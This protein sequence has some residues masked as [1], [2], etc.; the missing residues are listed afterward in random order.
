MSDGFTIITDLGGVILAVDK[1]RMC[2]ELARYSTLS[3]REIQSN[4]STTKLT[5]FDL[6]FG[7]GL[8]TPAGFY[9]ASVAKLKLSGLS[10]GKFARIYTDVFKRK[11]DTIRL[12]RKLGKKYTVALLSNTDA[13]HYKAWSGML[14]RDLKLFKQVTLSFRVHSAKPE[15]KIFLAA[16]KKLGVKP[17]QCVYIDDRPEYALAAVNVGMKGICF[18]SARQL[19]LALRQVGITV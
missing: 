8:L 10:F 7:K 3:A 18:V 6:G 19:R 11:E 16:V 14:G 2:R 15:R 9:K 17:Q 1:R 4:F 13:L 12:L 5:K